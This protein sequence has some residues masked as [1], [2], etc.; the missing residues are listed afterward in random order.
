MKEWQK[1][2]YLVWQLHVLF[3]FVHLPPAHA[4]K[5]AETVQDL[6]MAV[7]YLNTLHLLSFGLFF[8]VDFYWVLSKE[9]HDVFVNCNICTVFH[10]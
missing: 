5:S 4:V 1:T 10:N 7:D 3:P 2:A 9:L 8:V 6:K